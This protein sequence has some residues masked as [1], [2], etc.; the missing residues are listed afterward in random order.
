MDDM[1]EWLQSEIENIKRRMERAILD[2][3]AS[4]IVCQI[5]GGELDGQEAGVY[6]IPKRLFEAVDK[7]IL[8]DD[9]FFVETTRPQ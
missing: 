3:H 2:D 9:G 4:A 7:A 5:H 8:G 1:H 6:F